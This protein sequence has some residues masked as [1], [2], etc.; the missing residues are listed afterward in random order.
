L[1]QIKELAAGFLLRFQMLA[2]L[3]MFSRLEIAPTFAASAGSTTSGLA[4]IARTPGDE[5]I[6][7]ASGPSSLKL[8]ALDQILTAVSGNRTRPHRITVDNRV[9]DELFV[10][11]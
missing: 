7:A 11:N 2:G 8:A 1:C 5:P 4:S 9:L 3:L 10:L 6:T